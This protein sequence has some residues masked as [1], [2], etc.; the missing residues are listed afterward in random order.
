MFGSVARGETNENRDLDLLVAWE[1]GRSLLDHA[2]VEHGPH[3][4][5][6]ALL[7][8]SQNTPR[9]CRVRLLQFWLASG[10]APQLSLHE[11]ERQQQAK[12]REVQRLLLRAHEAAVAI[13]TI[14]RKNRGYYDIPALNHRRRQIEAS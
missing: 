5:I 11:I 9:R 7:Q 3:I 8:V 6:A 10:S 1:A 14:D 13:V 12:G 2:E 4:P